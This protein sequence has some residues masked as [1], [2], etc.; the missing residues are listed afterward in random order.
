MMYRTRAIVRQLPKPKWAALVVALSWCLIT[1]AR[2]DG[3]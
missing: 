1:Q 2:T 3:D